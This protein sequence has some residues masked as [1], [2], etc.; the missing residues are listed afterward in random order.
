MMIQ[1]ILLIALV[2][3]IS[4]CS[5]SIDDPR[6]R[7]SVVPDYEPCC[8]RYKVYNVRGYIPNHY[9]FLPSDVYHPDEK[10]KRQTID[11]N[12]YKH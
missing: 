1:R 3:L 11:L 4:G 12:F 8:G 2:F 6:L 10:Y 7:Y 5:T 9:Y